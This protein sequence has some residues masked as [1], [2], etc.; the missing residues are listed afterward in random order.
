[1]LLSQGNCL[2][3]MECSQYEL[4]A[5][6]NKFAGNGMVAHQIKETGID[7]MNGL[8]STASPN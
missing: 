8:T 5:T 2:H 3:N 6:K 7:Y 4:Y 1:M